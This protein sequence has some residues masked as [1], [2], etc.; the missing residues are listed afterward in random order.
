MSAEVKECRAE[1]MVLFELDYGDL[2]RPNFT[3]LR[4]S[5]WAQCT[6]LTDEY[7]V[8]FGPMSSRISFGPL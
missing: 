2:L 3:I 5:G 8:V 1:N 4:S 6:N 7:L